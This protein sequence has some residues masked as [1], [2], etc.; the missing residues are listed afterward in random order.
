MG[1]T[2]NRKGKTKPETKAASTRAPPPAPAPTDARVA[3]IRAAA[4][5]AAKP[6]ASSSAYLLVVSPNEKGGRRFVR[7]KASTVLAWFQRAWRVAQANGDWSS[8]LRGDV[9]GLGKLFD[10]IDE[11]NLGCPTTDKELVP[12]LEEHI[13]YEKDIEA[14]PH[15]LHV[16]TDDDEVDIEYFFFDDEFLKSPDALERLPSPTRPPPGW[17]DDD[18]DDEPDDDQ[19][20]GDAYA[21]F[22]AK[23]SDE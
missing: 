1:K 13:Y 7:L 10:M 4:A 11:Q 22:V 16:E 14:E 21:A 8:D 5:K 12:L 23:L 18:D 17:N 9:Y 15:F 20:G 6:E 2:A 19:E 3:A